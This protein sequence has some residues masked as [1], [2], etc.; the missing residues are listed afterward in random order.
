MKYARSTLALA[1]LLIVAKTFAITGAIVIGV[2]LEDQKATITILNTT[3][4]NITCYTVHLKEHHADGTEYDGHSYTEDLGT[5]SS[6]APASTREAHV[7]VDPE[8]KSVEAEAVVVVYDDRTAQVKPG[9]E[10]ELESIKE[11]R[12]EL[13]KKIAKSADELASKDPD[14]AERLR[15]KAKAVALN[16]DIRRLP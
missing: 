3:K 6:V 8:V 9:E 5:E 7:V 12:K 16:A 15:Q 11:T 14:E 10:R 13:A 1:S 4:H 2:H